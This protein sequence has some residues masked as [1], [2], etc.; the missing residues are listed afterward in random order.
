MQGAV[1]GPTMTITISTAGLE[2]TYNAAAVYTA[3]AR[4]IHGEHPARRDGPVRPS[5]RAL[6]QP[7]RQVAAVRILRGGAPT[8]PVEVL[9]EVPAAQTVLNYAARLCRATHPDSA[10]STD[11]VKRFVRYGS[12]PRGAQGMIAAVSSS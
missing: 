3:A 6:P 8:L 5:R 12:S 9:R 4:P 11:R 10:E 2:D 7:P 1:W